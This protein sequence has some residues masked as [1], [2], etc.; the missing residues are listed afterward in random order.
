MTKV[1]DVANSLVTW[2]KAMK[3]YYNINCIV[4]PKKAKLAEAEAKYSDIMSK[5]AIKQAELK[6]VIDKVEALE[7]DLNMNIEK[8]HDLERQVLD[9]EQR[10][11][12]AVKLIDGLGG[13]KIRWSE[14]A[15]EMKVVYGNLTGDVLVSSGMIAYLGAF[16]ATFR[17][18]LAEEWVR[19]C[20]DKNIPSGEKDFS[21]I[22]VLGDPVKIRAWNIDGLPSDNF[23]VENAII[24]KKAR[25]WPLAIDPQ[26]Q[27]NKWIR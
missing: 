11:E 7:A 2:I 16:T 10:L 1:S 20:R 3:N 24:I 6:Q 19:L 17:N 26:S 25:R 4:R 5:L 8:Q 9:C 15:A 18:I 22:H 23:S 13:E 27:A 21:L 14:T 12:K